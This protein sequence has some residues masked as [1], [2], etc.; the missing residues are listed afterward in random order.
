[1]KSFNSIIM[2]VSN[3]NFFVEVTL[4]KIGVYKV[5]FLLQGGEKKIDNKFLQINSLPT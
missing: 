5:T 4:M 1:M 2:L 3:F